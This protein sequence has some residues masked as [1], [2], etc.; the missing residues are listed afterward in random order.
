MRKTKV[1]HIITR[2]IRGGAEHNTL[3][4]AQGLAELGYDVSLVAGPS[5]KIEGD[6]EFAYRQADIKLK[7]FP[8]LVREISPLKDITSFLMLYIFI[9]KERFDIVHTHVSKAGILGRWAAKMAGVPY[10]CHTTH[11]NIFGGYFSP[12]ISKLFILLNKITVIITDKMIT[13]T[14]IGKKQWLDQNIGK[15]SQYTSIYSGINLDEFNPQNYNIE[16]EDV[17]KKLGFQIDDFIIGNVGRIAPIK[18]HKYLI[19]AAPSIIEEIPQAKFLIVGDGP[20]RSEIETLAKKLGLDEHVVFL[21]MQENVP[22][23]LSIMNIFVLPSI[24]EGMGRALVEAMAMKLP[25][26]ATSVGGVVEVIKDGET[27]LLVPSEDPKALAGAICRLAK[28]AELSKRLARTAQKR[29]RSV[30]G[31]QEMVDKIST[32]YNNFKG[33]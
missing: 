24:N 16:N 20:N 28:N 8:S 1:L 14:N 3:L 32:V 27:G 31:A 21:G 18:G 13:I 22:E 33:F 11:G 10:I 15:P 4:S 5:D 9:R 6:L 25:C 29:A 7:L 26:V 12:L 30:F 17:K 23:L 19:Q 2:L